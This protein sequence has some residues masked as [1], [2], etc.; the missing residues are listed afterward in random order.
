MVALGVVG[1][2]HTKAIEL[3]FRDDGYTTPLRDLQ[4]F[5]IHIA[6]LCVNLVKF[7][8]GRRVLVDISGL[9]RCRGS[10]HHLY[11]VKEAV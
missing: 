6:C 9:A 10:R 5:L 3:V 1:W 7:E 2:V 11:F 4:L 8:R